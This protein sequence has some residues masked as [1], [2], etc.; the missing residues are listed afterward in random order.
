MDYAIDYRGEVFGDAHNESAMREFVSP[1]LDRAA[2]TDLHG[3]RPD[4]AERIHDPLDGGFV[5]ARARI[6]L[7]PF[8][9]AGALVNGRAVHEIVDVLVRKTRS[10]GDG[11]DDA[12][13]GLAVVSG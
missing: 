9:C 11:A 12:V 5:D 7:A 10:D 13:A 2:G 8:A 3:G 1:E 4:P 6:A